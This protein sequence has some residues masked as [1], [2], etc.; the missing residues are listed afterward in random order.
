V[1]DSGGATPGC[2]RSNDLAGK[3]T[4]LAYVLAIVSLR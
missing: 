3:S 2:A 4:T 1:E